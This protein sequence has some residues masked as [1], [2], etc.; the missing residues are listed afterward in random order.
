[1]GGKFLGGV[2]ELIEAESDGR[3]ESKN[4]K[5]VH[6]RTGMVKRYKLSRNTGSLLPDPD[7]EKYKVIWG[8]T[9]SETEG[10]DRP[11]LVKST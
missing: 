3:Y 1:M 10:E 8:K 11:P 4:S 9:G 7:Y 6:R 2:K 5:M